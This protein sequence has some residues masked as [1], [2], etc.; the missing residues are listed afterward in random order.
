MTGRASSVTDN[1]FQQFET[2]TVDFTIR[3]KTGLAAMST[4]AEALK[5]AFDNA[6]MA[7]GSSVTLL[8]FWYQGESHAADPDHPNVWDWTVTY[9]AEMEQSKTLVGA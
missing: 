3:A 9:K 2:A 1:K 4:L 7:L 5:T 6:V 8:R